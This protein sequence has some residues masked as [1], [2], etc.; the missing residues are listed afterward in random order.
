VPSGAEARDLAIV[1]GRVVPAT[2]APV[3]GGTVL[4]TDGRITAVGADV[5]VPPGIPAVDASGAWVLPG[6]VD[7]H[8]HLGID[9]EA[10]GWAGNDLNETPETNGARLRAIDAINPADI[11]FRDALGGGIT[12]VVVLPGS[13]NPIGGQA[14]ALKCWGGTVDDRVVLTPVGVKSAGREPETGAL[15]PER[16]AFHPA[17]CGGRDPGRVRRRTPPPRPCRVVRPDTGRAGAGAG[18]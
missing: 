12:T 8:T 17:G 10:S 15:E 16:T 7:A 18:R 4:I 11:G 3:A 13:T 5:A 9:E 1:G 14:A 2:S 6:L